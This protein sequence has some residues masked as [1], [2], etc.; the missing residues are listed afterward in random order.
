MG[1]GMAL[2]IHRPVMPT[3]TTPDVLCQD[4]HEKTLEAHLADLAKKLRELPEYKTMD[5]KLTQLLIERV[6]EKI[7]IQEK[8]EAALETPRRDVVGFTAHFGVVP[9]TDAMKRGLDRIHEGFARAQKHLIDNREESLAAEVAELEAKYTKAFVE[10]ESL[11]QATE[12]AK[13][14]LE[15]GYQVIVATQTNEQLIHR[16]LEGNFITYQE[17][18]SKASCQLSRIVPPLADVCRTLRTAFGDKVEDYTGRSDSLSERHMAR[19]QF[20]AAKLPMLYTTYA[21]GGGALSLC[22]MDYP[23]RAIVGGGSPRVAIFLGSPLSGALLKRAVGLIWRPGVKSDAHAVFL[24]TD[25]ETEVRLMQQSAGPLLRVLGASVMGESTSLASALCAYPDEQRTRALEDALA[26]AEGDGIRMDTASFQVRSKARIVGI[27]DWSLIK[28]PSAEAAKH[29]RIVVATE[30]TDAYVRAQY[31]AEF[32]VQGSDSPKVESIKETVDVVDVVTSDK[33]LPDVLSVQ[34]LDSADRDI[35]LPVACVATDEELGRVREN[36]RNADQKAM[37]FLAAL[38]AMLA[39]LITHNAPTGWF[40]DIGHW[41]LVD[42]VGMISMLGLA[43]A[44]SMM[45]AVLY[46]SFMDVEPVRN[47]TNLSKVCIVKYRTLR[48]GFWVGT[49]AAFLSLLFLILSKRPH[50]VYIQRHY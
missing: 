22:D 20:L 23:D 26:Y 46:P 49:V 10:R 27:N 1:D 38:I 24:T 43:V 45:L 31:L 28:L 16:T 6:K 4:L 14:A 33:G 25:S 19:E 41:Q 2:G 50:Q 15:A 44:A 36:V 47:L 11:P 30:L 18:Y 3:V 40:K 39:F 8:A 13:R 5:R 12:I 17:L 21:I 9:V 37:F 42:V 32:C 7:R 48:R 35:S 34:N 29:K